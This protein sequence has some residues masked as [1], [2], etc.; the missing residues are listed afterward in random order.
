MIIILIISQLLVYAV[1]LQPQITSWGVTKSEMSAPMAGDKKDLLVT[2]TRGIVINADKHSVWRWL[3]QLGADRAGFYSYNFI[4]NAL[5]YIT[6]YPD[7]KQPWFKNL[8]VG[9]VVRGS[10]NNQASLIPYN[11]TVAYIKPED[12][13]VLTNWGT[14]LLQT[15]SDNQTK[16]IVRTQIK[17]NQNFITRVFNYMFVPFHYIMERR[18]LIGIKLHAEGDYGFNYSQ[19]AD[20]LWCLSMVLAWIF[21]VLLTFIGRGLLDRVLLP[22]CM[23]TL[24]MIVLL[25]CNPIP[26]YSVLLTLILFLI[27]MSVSLVRI[28]QKGE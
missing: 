9:D 2:S 19:T 13:F 3:M 22:I 18:M 20:I 24:W 17:S 25:I 5:G 11:F 4:E 27:N 6:R 12:T 23:T 28:R 7:M 16:L 1:F 8:Q 26:I 21:L 10:A 14:F 15:T